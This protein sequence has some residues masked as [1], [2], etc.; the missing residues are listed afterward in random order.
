MTA[1]H[2]LSAA[3]LTAIAWGRPDRQVI[4][5]LYRADDSRLLLLAAHALRSVGA[6]NGEA[7]LSV[8]A[9]GQRRDP[10]AV[11]AILR[12]GWLG[13]WAA[14]ILAGTEK[15]DAVAGRL[16]VLAAVA[17]LRT[18]VHADLTIP[19]FRESLH[20]PGTG[21]V[22]LN[23]TGDVEVSVRERLIVRSPHA[24]WSPARQLVGDGIRLLFDDQDPYR[25]TFRTTPSRRVSDPDLHSWRTTLLE[26]WELLH[27]YATPAAEQVGGGL[28]VLVPLAATPHMSELSV[29]SADALGALAATDPVDA[30]G[31]AMTLVHEWSHSLLNGLL[32][33]CVLHEPGSPA[34]H[35]APW[36]PDPR[37]LG[38]LLHGVFA[39]LAVAE[40]QQAL[41]SAGVGGDR[42]ENGFALRRAQLAEVMRTLPEASGLTSQG[43]RFT[44]ILAHR[45]AALGDTPVRTTAA[46]TAAARVA[47]DRA[48][49]ERRHQ[50]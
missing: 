11:A 45:S 38:G 47:A 12:E 2:R 32:E 46:T 13:P 9:E 24:G 14:R 22:R 21:T 15:P 44:A 34:V 33:F 48:V 26:A 43:R 1:R 3:Q 8:L 37:P 20:F 30:P 40:T 6:V 50:G 39:F 28:R 36:R 17:A 49:W 29:S 25:D 31:F 7:A 23:N 16:S 18:G 10:A 4:E 27:R 5:A 35:F 42:V 19:A 41:L